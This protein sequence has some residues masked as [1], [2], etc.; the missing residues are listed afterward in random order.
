MDTPGSGFTE[1]S[2]WRLADIK[3]LEQGL[4]AQET[5]APFE[6]WAYNFFLLYRLFFSDPSRSQRSAGIFVAYTVSVDSSLQTLSLNSKSLKYIILRDFCQDICTDPSSYIKRSQ[7]NFSAN[8]TLNV[9]RTLIS[10]LL[11][12]SSCYSSQLN[13]EVVLRGELRI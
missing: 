1:V 5:Y 7:N 8:G 9:M 13:A 11:L 4:R 10:H 12:P 6:N 2:G 3:V